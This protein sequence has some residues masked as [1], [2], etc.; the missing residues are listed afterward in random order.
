MKNDESLSIFMVAD[1]F[2]F[3]WPMAE[4]LQPNSLT[5]RETPD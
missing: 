4:F 5:L 3:E 1:V 2:H